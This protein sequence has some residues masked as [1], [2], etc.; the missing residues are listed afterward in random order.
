MQRG[1]LS[2]SLL[3][4]LF[5]FELFFLTPL[6]FYG[7]ATTFS[8]V[9]QT[10]AELGIIL[11]LFL[12]LFNV[13][14]RIKFSL[15]SVTDIFIIIFASFLVLSLAWTSSLYA[16]F[17]SLGVWASYF[18]IYFIARNII[19]EEKW[20]RFLVIAVLFSGAHMEKAYRKNETFLNLW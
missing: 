7:W 15:P 17:T 8:M 3:I 10:F 19:K 11:I 18:C 4:C 16:S 2:L 5:L 13:K 9:K 6:V 12:F 1:K 14:D 20:I